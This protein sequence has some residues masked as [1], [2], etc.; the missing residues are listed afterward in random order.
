MEG[1]GRVAALVRGAAAAFRRSALHFHKEV[2]MTRFRTLDST[3]DRTVTARSLRRERLD[4]MFGATE[5][6]A[7]TASE[8]AVTGP[9]FTDPHFA[10]AAREALSTD[11]ATFLRDA[12]QTR[13]E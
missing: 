6:D 5:T 7:M 3:L 13:G 2:T 4:Q 12:R 8:A 10:A 11:S 1:V 9:Q